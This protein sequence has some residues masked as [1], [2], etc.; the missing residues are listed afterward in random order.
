MAAELNVSLR[1][2]ARDFD[3]LMN[4]LGVPLKYDFR[5]KSYVLT[6]EIPPILIDPSATHDDR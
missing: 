3:Y 5:K 6:G 2:V 4:R 1:T